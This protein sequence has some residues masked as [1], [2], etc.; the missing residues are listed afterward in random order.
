MRNGNNAGTANNLVFLFHLLVVTL[1][2]V[3]APKGAAVFGP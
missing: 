1:L 2:H 3:V